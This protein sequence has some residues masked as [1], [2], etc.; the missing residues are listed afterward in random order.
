[1]YCT[2]EE[3]FFICQSGCRQYVVGEK[4]QKRN[5][6]MLEKALVDSLN[7]SDRPTNSEAFDAWSDKQLLECFVRQ[8]TEAVF[9]ELVRRHGPMVY[10]VCRRVLRH[11][12]DA[13]DAFQATFLILARKA[14]CL[15]KP[16]ML[17]NWLYGVA[18]RTALHARNQNARRRQREQ[19]AAS[20]AT[21]PPDPP[22]EDALELP[23]LLEEELQRLPEKYRVP[24]VLCYLEGKTHVEAACLLRLP[25]GSMSS[26]LSRGREILRDRLSSRLRAL[27]GSLL[28]M[29]WDEWLQ[30]ATVPPFLAEATV[31]AAL[32]LLGIKV[33][34]AGW[35]SDTVRDLI[36]VSLD[37]PRASW[38]RWLWALV[39]LLLLVL[40]LS[41]AVSSPNRLPESGGSA[42]CKG[43]STHAAD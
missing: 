23:R 11:T 27:S 8:R 34:A 26:R 4:Q 42:G 33:L 24:L 16:E 36:D 31:Q 28:S 32:G 13:E 18:S 29:D 43:C 7:L 37:E 1:M 21:L 3:F 40:G 6:P 14:G 15:Q 41:V 22:Q 5:G 20:L 25:T 2:P 12:Q 17:A 19:K 9:A 38:L 35:I 30:P 10:G 39:L